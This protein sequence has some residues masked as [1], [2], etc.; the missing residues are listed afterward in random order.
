MNDLFFTLLL[1]NKAKERR[2]KFY[3]CLVAHDMAYIDINRFAEK[4]L[5]VVRTAVRFVTAVSSATN[6]LRA[7]GRHI[8]QLWFSALS[9]A[10]SRGIVLGR[11]TM[12]SYVDAKYTLTSRLIV[13]ARSTVV[14]WKI[15][16][17]PVIRVIAMAE[18]HTRQH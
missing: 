16:W 3:D 2:Y 12:E 17:L 11:C 18:G 10:M 6:V 15:V 4:V 1:Y 13:V 7:G 14:W 9:S 8:V 5:V